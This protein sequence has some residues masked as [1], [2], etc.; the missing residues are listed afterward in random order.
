MAAEAALKVAAE[1]LV[2]RA[3]HAMAA[4]VAAEGLAGAP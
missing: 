3:L 1:G 4:E 2:A